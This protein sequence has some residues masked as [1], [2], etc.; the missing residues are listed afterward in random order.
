MKE[1]MIHRRRKKGNDKGDDEKY[2]LDSFQIRVEEESLCLSVRLLMHCFEMSMHVA[3]LREGPLT[4]RTRV[5][6][7]SRVSPLMFGEGR[8][9]SEGVRTLITLEGL[10]SRVN[11]HVSCEG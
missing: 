4:N 8:V 6:F 9:V 2:I 10:F 11:P 3:R 7:L 5:G 1:I